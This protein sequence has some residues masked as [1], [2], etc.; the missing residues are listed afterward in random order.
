MI[1]LHRPV[2]KQRAANRQ[3]VCWLTLETHRAEPPAGHP[4]QKRPPLDEHHELAFC[5]ILLHIAM[6]F[7][8]V[9]ERED[10]IEAEPIA[11]SSHPIHELLQGFGTVGRSHTLGAKLGQ[12][13]GG[14]NGGHGLKVV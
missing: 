2:W 8:N 1:C 3:R 14:G 9:L 4:S 6:R 11:T 7:D 12:F 10:L 13:D 5:P